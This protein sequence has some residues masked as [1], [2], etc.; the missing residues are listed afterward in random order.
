MGT[1]AA[2]KCTAMLQNSLS[3]IAFELLSA[4]QAVDIRKNIC[5]QE[6]LSKTLEDV[7]ELVRKDIPY[8]EKD[9]E[10]RIDIEKIEE[11]IR[12][13]DIREIV[14]RDCADFNERKENE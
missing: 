14:Y 12:K 2:R 7:Y 6:G 10:I 5:N 4:C 11:I 1:T 9:R 3:V 13:E 8:M